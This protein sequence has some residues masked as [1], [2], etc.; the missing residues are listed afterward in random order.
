MDKP[1]VVITGGT[2]LIGSAL[3]Q[4]L[5][6][7][8]YRVTI[9]TRDPQKA[10]RKSKFGGDVAYAAWGIDTRQMEEKVLTDAD[11]IIHLAGVGVVDSKWTESY[12]R[13]IVDSRVKS[14]EMLVKFLIEKP[15]KVKAVVSSSAVGWYGADDD[16][17]TPF[18]ETD[19]PDSG[20]LG[21]TCRLW[22]GAMAPVARLGKRQV[23]LRTG[24]VLSTNGGA[25]KEF[26]KPLHF[27]VAGIFG[28]GTQMISW[29][30]IDDLCR[31]YLYALENE[32]MNGVY[33][34]V[35][36][37]PVSNMHLNLELGRQMKDGFFVPL[38]VPNFLL[39]LRLGDRTIEVLKSATVS[40]EKIKKE[41][42]EFL[43][44]TI[45]RALRHLIKRK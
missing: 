40:A 44:P 12:K 23:W 5:T 13:Q 45:S 7:K 29:I 11:Y 27:F 15:N 38:P 1:H 32:N 6:D 30:H 2:G 34:A 26:M 39:K 28:G 41:G 42:F 35:A 17:G 4:L 14:G 8:G 21:E 25:L 43:Y 9:F 16:R 20:F 22:E 24:I 10:A 33:N 36:P 37:M 3:T 19:P 18:V 31:M